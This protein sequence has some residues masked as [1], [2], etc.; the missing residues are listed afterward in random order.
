MSGKVT[1]EELAKYVD[2]QLVNL[3]LE[4][5]ALDRI[6]EDTEVYKMRAL[7]EQKNKLAL[8]VDAVVNL[9]EYKKRKTP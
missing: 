1:P 2:D 7:L 9:L 5:D 6:D 4:L 8:S 3:L